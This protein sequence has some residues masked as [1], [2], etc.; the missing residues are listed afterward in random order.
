MAKRIRKISLYRQLKTKQQRSIVEKAI[1][2]GIINETGSSVSR[3]NMSALQYYCIHTLRVDISDQ[4]VERLLNANRRVQQ[5][6]LQQQCR[7]SQTEKVT[8]L[9]L[10]YRCSA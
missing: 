1:E 7:L 10:R 2:L 3:K 5:V 6:S 9:G 8:I 4:E